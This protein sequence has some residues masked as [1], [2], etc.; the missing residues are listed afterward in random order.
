VLKTVSKSVLFGCD[1]VCFFVSFFCEYLQKKL[2]LNNIDE[3]YNKVILKATLIKIK[4]N[5]NNN[6]I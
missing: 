6:K 2:P 5:N 3:I 1:F 4:N